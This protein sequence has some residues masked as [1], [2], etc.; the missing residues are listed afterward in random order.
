MINKEIN[1][2]GYSFL[3]NSFTIMYLLCTNKQKQ[4]ITFFYFKQIRHSDFWILSKTH[5]FARISAFLFIRTY[6][7]SRLF[8]GVPRTNDFKYNVFESG[9]FGNLAV[10][11][12]EN[13][14][15][16][17]SKSEKKNYILII[18]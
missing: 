8:T 17:L 9:D 14:S 2:D 13:G 6:C 16:K 1:I 3:N 7:F 12:F 5:I 15:F 4:N 11:L 10:H 18:I